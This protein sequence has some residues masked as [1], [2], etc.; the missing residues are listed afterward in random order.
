MTAYLVLVMFMMYGGIG[1]V[2]AE[3]TSD[4]RWTDEQKLLYYLRRNYD[5]A[6][7]PVFNASHPIVVRL[8]ITLAQVLD[9]DEKNQ[10]IT[11]SVWLDQEWYD[12]KLTWN[13][14]LF[15]NI[16]ILRI[17]CDLVWLP[18][19]IL[20]N[21]VDN[22]H[23]GYMRSLVMV[24]ENGNVF[25][26]PIV[27]MR[28]SCKM[29]ITYFPFDDQ[30]CKLK[31][32]SWAYDGFQLDV[33][34]RTMEV[35]TENYVDNG[36][37][38]LIDTQVTRNVVYY[39]CCPEPFPDITFYIHI[40]RRVLYY[41]FNVIVPCVLLSS[42]SLTG[43]LLPSD[44]GEKVTLGLTVLLAFSVFMLLVAE[45]MPPTSEYVPLI[46]IYLTV[47]MAM[48]A[49][50]VALAVFV[51]SCHHRGTVV[52]L[53]PRP[54]RIL[55][56]VIGRLLCMK[57]FYIDT[58]QASALPSH[59]IDSHRLTTDVTE[60]EISAFMYSTPTFKST[61]EA[62]KVNGSLQKD[63]VVHLRTII[64]DYQKSQFD[65]NVVLQWRE[66][67]QVMDRCFFVLF[68]TITLASSVVLLIVRPMTK[69]TRIAEM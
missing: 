48:S 58:N 69:A 60:I 14:S 1:A 22:H 34:K 31:L 65:R 5:S 16:T 24:Q 33:V 17:P 18:D 61:I 28:S 62:M 44:S 43:F 52:K 35:D 7:R 59:L 40:R 10:I 66:I 67:A 47:I 9:V 4:V 6:V 27:R 41:M 50:S 46:G 54:V 25:W 45:N 30:V 29:D 2:F 23:K 68:L 38:V 21:S 39:A 15:A 20:Y 37:W 11:L 26:P 3:L 36:E 8:G 13:K 12:E 64:D 49:I 32:G 57:L 63:T 56:S 19:I 53:P 55:A 51:L 42:L